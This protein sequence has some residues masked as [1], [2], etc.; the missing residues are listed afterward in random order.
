M[1]GLSN[2]SIAIFFSY[3]TTL[4]TWDRAGFLAREARWIN[5]LA[6]RFKKIYLITYGSHSDLQYA[7]LF[8][9][10]VSILCNKRAL[11]N[12]I[13]S[14]LLPFIYHRQLKDVTIY[15]T[16]QVYGSWTPIISKILSKG[17]K[18]VVRQGYRLSKFARYEGGL[19]RAIVLLLE[20]LIFTFADAVIVTSHADVN[21]I[22]S[23]NPNLDR[24]A[25]YLPNYVDADLFKP[26][27]NIQ[28]K[29][30]ICFVGRLH[31]QKNLINLLKAVKNLN[32]RLTIVGD[33]PLRE[34]V[35]HLVKVEKMSHVRLL[36]RLPYTEL[37]N[38]FNEHEIFVLPSS[39]EG[40]PKA[41]LEA[42]ACELAVIATNIEGVNELINH[43]KNGYLC[44]LSSDSIKSAISGLLNNA[45]LRRKLSQS[46]RKFVVKNFCFEK[47]FRKELALYEALL[48]P[49]GEEL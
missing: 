32:V 38:I 40:N 43:L 1:N 16:I 25:I 37:P 10:N 11:P 22:K 4:K 49:R 48:E 19:F 14:V 21:Y 15:R 47:I 45:T 6:R 26:S 41:L 9:N 24:K 42:M 34:A 5:E 39:Y 29:E 17:S 18:L 28:R 33:G 31:P 2:S 35:E 3:G 7:K 46:A 44:C 36:G 27:T 13:Y 8:R 23:K 30:G 20:R 12:V